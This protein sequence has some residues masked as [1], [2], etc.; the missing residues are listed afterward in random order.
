MTGF[1]WVVSYPKS[2]NTWLRLALRA[3]LHPD[4]GAG[5]LD[6][7]GFAPDASQRT[8]I[9]E[10]LDVESGDLTPAELGRL[11]PQA[12]RALAATAT[13]PLFRKVH[14]AQSGTADGPLF[15]PEVTLGTLYVVRDPRDV[16]VSWAHFAGVGLDEAIAMLCDPAA[17]LQAPAGRPAL[18]LPQRLGC[19]SS[20][21]RSWLDAPGR[22]CCLLRYEDMLADPA[23]VLRRAA[24][25]AGIPHGEADI[26]NAV[27]L[28]RF[29]ALRER[30]EAHGFDGG[31]SGGVPF[32][33]SGRA[34]QWRTALSPEQAGRVWDVHRE[35]M[36]RIGYIADG[37][38]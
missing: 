20:H 28:T 15:P 8:D 19:W 22:S 12:Y 14:D 4:R 31:Q 36:T 33:R 13:R 3:L 6:A 34:G 25:Y 11:R 27:A 21:V 32:F 29:D 2:G 16:V 10:A 18:T 24:L 26:R 5:P 17:V 7:T 38:A 35:M 37:W 1:Y 9:E 23:A 30:E